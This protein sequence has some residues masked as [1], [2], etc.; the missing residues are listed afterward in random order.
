MLGLVITTELSFT[1]LKS[2]AWIFFPEVPAFDPWFIQ[3]DH[4]ISELWTRYCNLYPA[5]LVKVKLTICNALLLLPIIVFDVIL[6]YVVHD[7]SLY[8]LP[9]NFA[10]FTVLDKLIFIWY[11]SNDL[12]VVP[13]V[14]GSVTWSSHPTLWQLAW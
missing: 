4:P 12:P 3:L 13:A 11:K 7:P 2:I 10:D 5:W 1:S 6:S 8:I 9:D 14:L